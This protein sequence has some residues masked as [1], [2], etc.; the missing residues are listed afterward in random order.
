L[1]S[2]PTVLVV[3]DEVFV[4]DSLVDL[5]ENEGYKALSAG[6]AAEGLK[7][8]GTE[9]VSVVIT[10]L[11]M[12]SG[13]GL[14]LLAEARKRMLD[15][16][17]IL[18]TGVGT[19]PDAVLAMKSGAYDFILKPVD[20]EQF[21]L[22][23]HRAIEHHNLVSELSYLKNAV[24]D[25]RGPTEMVGKSAALSQVRTLV[26]QVSPTNATV[27]ITGE[28]GT[29]KELVAAE[30]HRQSGRAERNFVSV[31]CA[32]I[33]ENLFESEFFGH[34]RGAFTSATSDRVGR[35]AEAEGGT[36][37]LDEIGTLKPEMQAKLLRVLETGEYQV[38]GESRTRIADVR[39][40]AITNEDLAA[41]VREGAFRKDLYF[42][43]NVFPIDVPPLRRRKEDIPLLAEH[44]FARTREKLPG[45]PGLARALSHEVCE[46]LCGYDWPGNVRE[47]RNVMERASILSRNGLADAMTF[48]RILAQPPAPEAAG[49]SEEEDLHIRRRV[50]AL[51]RRLIEAA[52]AR[53]KGKKREA[54]VLLG[55]DAKNIGYYLRKHGMA[56]PGSETGEEGG[57]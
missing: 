37:T 53:V 10:D 24:K 9:A 46:V 12:P 16:P 56:E 34:R 39:V 20:P 14:S 27:L 38:L 19:V 44:F 8:L 49:G 52:L 1:S 35:F 42:R 21:V 43:L 50:D 22:L 3:D 30:V 26:A 40:I 7:I 13:D 33:P 41:R 6:S 55:I 36:V 48:R 11:R 45:E 23:T 4:R 18:L 57:E 47:L 15:V 51:E 17:V 29:G 32:A 54:A 5:L 28:S 25:L 2:K 31:N